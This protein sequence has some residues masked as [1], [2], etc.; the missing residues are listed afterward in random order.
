MSERP[1]S[2]V[3]VAGFLFFATVIALFVGTSLL[4][5]N[6]LMYHLWQLNRP[7][8]TVFVSIRGPASLFLVA[9]GVATCVAG[10]GLLLRKRWAWWFAVVL[11][12]V[13]IAGDV[14]SFFVLRDLL[15]MIVGVA[16]SG[17]FVMLM[18]GRGVRKWFFGAIG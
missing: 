17:L 5:P 13:N 6:P 12:A 16:V 9:L 7:G 4:F 8:E 11:F 3:V 2:V 1:S 14:I 10:V 18:I 15:R